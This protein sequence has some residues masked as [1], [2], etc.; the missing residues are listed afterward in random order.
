MNKFPIKFDQCPA[1]SSYR[2]SVEEEMEEEVKA[3]RLPADSKTG[4]MMTRTAL[5]DPMSAATGI[6]AKREVTML[7][8]LYDTCFDCGTLYLV[9][10]RRQVT[11]V[12]PQINE[13]PR[14]DDGGSPWKIR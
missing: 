4:V 9:E 3:G 5:F 7:V 11:T 1:C 2:R 8:G 12:T 6:L 10:M 13:P 14:E